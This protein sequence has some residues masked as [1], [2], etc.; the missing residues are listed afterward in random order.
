MEATF[1]FDPACPFTWATSRWLVDVAA[2]RDVTVRW[3]PFSLA[4]LNGADVPEK[5]RPMM[6]ASSRALRLVAALAADHRDSEIGT[7]Y[8]ELGERTFGADT[9][10][11]DEVV[12]AAAAAAGIDDAKAALD[13]AAWDDSVRASHERAMASA[14]PGIGSPV[15][16]IEGAAR[17]IHGPVIALG[18]Q[19]PHDEALAIWDATVPLVRSSTFFEIKRGRV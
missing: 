17:G 10:M 16:E 2:E 9:M 7:F 11:S 8:T 1:S 4:I 18:E 6:A 19:P 13:D 5:Y 12:D 14:G 3:R 15:L